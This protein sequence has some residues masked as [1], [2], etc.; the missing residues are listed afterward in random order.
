MI[1]KSEI[2]AAAA[3]A[4]LLL[5]AVP[6]SAQMM[7]GG[8]AAAGN[9]VGGVEWGD[10]P[11][12]PSYDAATEYRN[13]MAELQAGKFRDAERSFNHALSVDRNNADTY[14]QLGLAKAGEGDLSGAK[15][16]YER[17]LKLDGHPINVRR[18]YAVALAKLNQPAK[19]QAQLDIL[20][21]QANAC[22]AG[23]P[24]AGDLKDAVTA[25]EAAMPPSAAAPKAG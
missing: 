15:N 25:V 19:A 16:A 12:G 13:G 7:G 18:D 23:C 24:M 2:I 11:R 6:A 20:K 1:R 5:C 22:G 21:G 4:G 8:A 10:G 17:S 3:L 9:G 14:Y